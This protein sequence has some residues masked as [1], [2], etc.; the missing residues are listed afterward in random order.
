MMVF[1]AIANILAYFVIFCNML[2]D[3]IENLL[4][5]ID[6][7]CNVDVW[8]CEIGNMSVKHKNQ[9]DVLC[10]LRKFIIC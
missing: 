9:F 6:F 2:F 5:E 1:C 10:I 7:T 3:I 8:G 4:I